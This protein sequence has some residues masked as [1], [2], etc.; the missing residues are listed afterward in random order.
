MGNDSIYFNEK[1]ETM[2]RSELEALQVQRLK[3]TMAR[4]VNSPF[5]Q[6]VFK[7][8]GL[9]PDSIK[10]WTTSSGFPSP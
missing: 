9:S 1:F 8:N 4:A 5:Y 7:E 2:D 3:Q 6:R 10:S